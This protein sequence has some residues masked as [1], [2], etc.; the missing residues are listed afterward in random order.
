MPANIA[1]EIARAP[2]GD[3]QHALAEG[4]R[5]QIA[6]RQSN[7]DHS[8]D[9]PRRN[10]R[11]KSA[12]RKGRGIPHTGKIVALTADEG[13]ALC[14]ERGEFL[15]EPS[16]ALAARVSPRHCGSPSRR[17]LGTLV[18]RT[19]EWQ[20]GSASTRRRAALTTPCRQSEQPAFL[21]RRNTINAAAGGAPPAGISQ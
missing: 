14:R 18:A 7:P 1:M 20:A 10:Q 9:L 8:A 5:E 4:I 3:I 17:R 2:D 21:D 15:L 16:A 12:P 11:R 19:G 6:A 13:F